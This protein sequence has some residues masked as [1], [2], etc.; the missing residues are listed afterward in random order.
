VGLFHDE[1]FALRIVLSGV[2]LRS[3]DGSVTGGVEQTRE[4]LRETLG[5][6]TGEGPPR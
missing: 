1:T 4:Q 5:D 3:L 6:I 2:D